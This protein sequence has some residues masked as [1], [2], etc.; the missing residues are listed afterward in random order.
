MITITKS[1]TYRRDTFKRE[2]RGFREGIIY[3]ELESFII[4]EVPVDIIIQIFFQ[5]PLYD[6]KRAF[7]TAFTFKFRRS[8]YVCPVPTNTIGCPVSYVI[9]IAAPT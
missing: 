5:T 1:H 7:T 2:E 6:F 9:E 3:K 8:V 4:K